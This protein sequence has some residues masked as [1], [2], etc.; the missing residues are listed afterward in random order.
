[1]IQPAKS[2]HSRSGGNR[3]FTLIEVIAVLI[4]LGILAAV[5]LSRGMDTGEAK[6]RAEV[7]TLKAHVRY[8]QYLAMNENEGSSPTTETDQWGINIAGTSYS[9]VKVNT[10]S[11][12]TSPFNLPNESSATHSFPGGIIASSTVNPIF[13]DDW[14]SPGAS[15]I[16][17]TVGGQPFTITAETGFIP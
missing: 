14:G 7:D 10:T 4:I 15:N 12:T 13:F 3:G 17:V 11:G 9:L 8:A 5:A 6:V 2:I 16:T 1:M